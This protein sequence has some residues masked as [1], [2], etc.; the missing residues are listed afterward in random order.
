MTSRFGIG[1]NSK[2]F[3]LNATKLTLGPWN[4]NNNMQQSDTGLLSTVLRQYENT[5]YLHK[6]LVLS[7]KTA[8][9]QFGY[10]IA[11]HGQ[12]VLFLQL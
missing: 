10:Q 4:L 1:E 8:L 2:T 7:S 12:N 5:N 11:R 3:I 9:Q 6:I